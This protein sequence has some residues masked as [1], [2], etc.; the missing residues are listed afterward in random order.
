MKLYS[1]ILTQND[2]YKRGRTIK[3]KGVMVHST[4]GNNPNISRYVGPDDGIL[5]Y[6]RFGNHWNVSGL[7]VCVHAFIGKVAD[8]TIATYQTLPWNHRAWH[9]GGSGNNTHI[10]FEVCEDGLDDPDYFAKTYREAVELT[11]MLCKEYNLDPMADGV[12]LC[13]ADGYQR[14]TASNHGDVNHWW[15]KA[16]KTMSD[17]RRDVYNEMNETIAEEEPNTVT[18]DQFNKMMENWLT[19][20][21]ALDVSGWAEPELNQAKALGITDATRPQSFATRQEVAIM[22]ARSM[23]Q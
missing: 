12:I 3:P 13:H 8:G 22:I 21:G 15:P 9:C 18:Q 14:G 2:C 10:S 20:R 17:F 16:G 6:N 19:A 4:G 7:P 23:E 5:G 1:C 11:A